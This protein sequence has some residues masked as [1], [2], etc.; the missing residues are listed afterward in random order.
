MGHTKTVIMLGCVLPP[1]EDDED[2]EKW[3]AF[4]ELIQEY[5]QTISNR[6]RWNDKR[7][8]RH[9]CPDDSDGTGNPTIGLNIAGADH[10]PELVACR[11]DDVET[12]YAERISEAR[13]E[14]RA[15]QKWARTKGLDI[16]E[17]SLFLA[18]DELA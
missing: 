16:P 10:V 6:K 4:L 17:P 14:W 1:I 7:I 18:R 13:S 5:G 9:P 8:P 12:V 15:F 3:D 11:V 2:G